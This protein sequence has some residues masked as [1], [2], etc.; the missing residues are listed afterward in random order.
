LADEDG[1]DQE[2]YLEALKATKGEEEIDE[3]GGQ[4]VAIQHIVLTLMI[5]LYHKLLT[6]L[7]L[8]DILPEFVLHL[9][10][11]MIHLLANLSLMDLHP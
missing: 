9:P 6:L 11:A 5:C 7:H 1:E 8:V 10:S 3:A 4:E 2:E